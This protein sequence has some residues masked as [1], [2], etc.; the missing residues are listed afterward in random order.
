[1]PSSKH[2]Y[3]SAGFDWGPEKSGFTPLGLDFPGI[4]SDSK[5]EEYKRRE[6]IEEFQRGILIGFTVSE[7]TQMDVIP[8]REMK[9]CSLKNGIVKLLQPPQWEKTPCR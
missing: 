8:V 9:S 7:L 1:M 2:K 5:T 4:P 3:G 6:T